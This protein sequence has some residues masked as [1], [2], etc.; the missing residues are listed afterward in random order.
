MSARLTT[1]L[2]CTALGLG[3]LFNGL[4]SAEAAPTCQTLYAGKTTNAGSVCVDND[5]DYLTVTYTTTGD[6]WIDDA[7]LFVGT[8]LSQ[9]P[10]T[11]V[12]NPKIGNFPYRAEDLDSQKHEIRIPL[13]DF[14][15]YT[16][17]TVLTLAAHAAL[18]RRDAAGTIYQTETGWA[19]GTRM[20]TKG[21]WAT[22]FTYA[23]QCP[24]TLRCE[25]AYALGDVTFIQL[26]I[27]D[28]R[29]G[30]QNTVPASTS[31]SRKIY[32]GAAQNDL[33]KG[34]YVGDLTY[35]YTGSVL[36][37]TYQMFS[38]W[39]M[40]KTHVY[41]DE[42]PVATIAPGKYGNQHSLTNA[43]TDSYTIGVTGNP[44]YVVA[45]AEACTTN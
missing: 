9:M 15:P 24:S 38:G 25:T 1:L 8:S 13:G 3:A 32:A 39:S 22:Y 44:I 33:N 42:S 36:N 30:W 26:G 45:H 5:A 34:T 43:A 14:K 28:S 2:A 37:L 21:S 40:K 31:G 18:Y 6:W 12:G 10:Q 17:G 4:A 29:W 41:A 23:I 16:C 20:T 11:S 27:T 35:S 19:S 7:H